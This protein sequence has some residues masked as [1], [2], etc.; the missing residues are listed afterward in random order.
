MQKSAI[1][2][3]NR[4]NEGGGVGNTQ[5]TWAK[6]KHNARGL[7]ESDRSAENLERN[8][9]GTNTFFFLAAMD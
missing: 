7:Q 2:K 4:V 8:F 6:D 5:S 3:L 9:S 1:C